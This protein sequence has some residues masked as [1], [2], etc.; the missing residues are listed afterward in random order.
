MSAGKDQL[1][2]LPIKKDCRIIYFCCLSNSQTCLFSSDNCTLD[3]QIFY[4]IPA[5][6]GITGFLLEPGQKI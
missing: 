3:V 6:A 1:F 2:L 5:K 4:V